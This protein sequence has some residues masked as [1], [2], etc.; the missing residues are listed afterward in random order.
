MSTTV[1]KRN[2]RRG[3]RSFDRDLITISRSPYLRRSGILGRLLSLLLLFLCLPVIATLVVLVRIGSRGP[4]LFKQVRVGKNGKIFVMY[5]I[6]SM[7]MD[8]EETTGPVWTQDKNDP[9]ITRLGVFLRKSHLDELPQL[10]NVV[11]GEMSLFGP[12]PERPEL[13]HILTGTVPGYLNRLAV[14]P[15]ITGLAQINLPPDSDI[16][17]VRR[18]LQLD[19][20]YIRHANFWLEFRMFLWTGLRLLAVSSSV[21]TKLLRLQR[22]VKPVVT[23]SGCP[24]TISEL[25]SHAVADGSVEESHSTS[26]TEP[27]VAT[28]RT[29]PKS[30]PC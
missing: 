6:R 7:V 24:V 16:E 19:L 11:R 5:K 8:A 9:R 25:L 26:L 13:V 12:R 27:V 28:M 14:Q 22:N 3:R 17:S 2:I 15:G 4:G 20:E 29:S 21:A 30:E 10:L 23:K 18:K 1:A